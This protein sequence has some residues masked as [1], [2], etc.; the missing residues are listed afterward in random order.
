M[1]GTGRRVVS[2]PARLP[3]YGHGEGPDGA[4][5]RLRAGRT[6]AAWRL[7]VTAVV[8]VLVAVTGIV[9]AVLAAQPKPPRAAPA[10]G[11]AP[12]T[13][14]VDAARVRSG[15]GAGAAVQGAAIP[16][17]GALLYGAA[18][19]AAVGYSAPRAQVAPASLMLTA[20]DRRDCPAKAT[21][22]VDLTRHITWLQSGGKTTFGPVAMEPGNP[23]AK[24]EN[25]TP[26]GTF[27]VSWKAGPQYRSTTYNEPMPWATFFAAGGIA[28]HG[29]SLTQWSHG[30]VHLTV[31]NA[32]YYQ[33]HLP[34]GAEV[35]VF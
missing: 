5:S 24:P 1:N 7:S 18:G 29:G 10:G 13:A 26:R 25:Q 20:A 21:A 17:S 4:W 19:A 3:G 15:P 32:H 27:H 16:Q 33:A 2:A 30:C 23:A 6:D 14:G 31:G 8:A 9:F 34:A 11:T 12:A 28:F 35:V 22:C